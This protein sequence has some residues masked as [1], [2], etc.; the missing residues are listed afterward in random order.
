MR[1]VLKYLCSNDYD[2]HRCDM[3]SFWERIY[4]HRNEIFFD[5]FYAGNPL[6]APFLGLCYDGSRLVGQEN[7]LSQNIA[8]A[9]NIYRGSM[10]VDT[11]LDPDYR[12]FYGIFGKLCK[13]T[14]DAL[15]DKS[16]ILFAYAN[17][18]SKRYYLK[19]F[20]WK[21]SAKIGVY[22][23]ITNFMGPN[24]RSL[25]AL[26][27]A[28]KN[29]PGLT[30]KRVEQFSPARLNPMLEKYRLEAH[31]AYFYKTAEYLNWKYLNNR[32][33]ETR[34]Y[35]IVY[36]DRLCGYCVTYDVENER[37][38]L[39]IIIA[40]DNPEIFRKVISRISY[41]TRKENLNILVIYAT[42]SAWY[43]WILS[44][45]AF[46]KR[47][48]IDYITHDYT[49]KIPESAWLVHCGDFDIY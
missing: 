9:G 26:L 49:I 3:L 24:P 8:Y 16:D 21:I 12:L 15:R 29:Y 45:M 6:G 11:L 44:R 39:D 25:L 36:D 23:K 2:A 27:S 43:K 48:E 40:N 46:F 47:R 19:Y 31:H 14:I 5:S 32:H 34:G 20:Q 1:R 17:E 41:A 13:M 22:K 7:Y 38:V 42:N 33:Y 35:E 4:G 10:G 18:E 37:R 30:L 28:G